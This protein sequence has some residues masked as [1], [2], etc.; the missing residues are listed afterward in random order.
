MQRPITGETI[1]SSLKI[2]ESQLLC[3]I[4]STLKMSSYLRFEA[5]NHERNLYRFYE[6]YFS[7]D[8]FMDWFVQTTYGKLGTHGRIQSYGFGAL[9][10]ALV[11]LRFIIRKR[12]NSQK[13]IGC[14]YQLT[15]NVIC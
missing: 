12:L 13:C 8:L 7:R 2:L 3:E 10:D 14:S 6:I 9:E 1:K 4:K 5:V 15:E 11:K